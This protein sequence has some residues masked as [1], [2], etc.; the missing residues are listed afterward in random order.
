MRL[1][2]QIE[3][4]KNSEVRESVE[5]RLKEF[6][7]FKNKNHEDWF[8]ELCFCL[9]TAN[10]K[11][12]TA[13][14]IQKILGGRGF[15][16]LEKNKLAFVIKNNHHRFHN[17][18]AKYIC[19]ARKFKYIKN[20][21]A[22]FETEQE[23]RDFIVENVRGLGMKESSHFLRN[24]GSKNLA[25]LDRHIISLMAENGLIKEVPKNLTYKKYLEIEEKF[26]GVAAGLGMS[27]AEL[28]LYMWY[29]KTGRVLK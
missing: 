25:I 21:L 11:A 23:A 9:L 2:K 28:D 26:L 18:K 4:L 22:K 29:L 20:I 13:I 15:L 17:H 3:V 8:S 16:E 27:A 7:D 19:D 10:S 1:E 24:T 14:Q 5:Q 12:Q 6:S